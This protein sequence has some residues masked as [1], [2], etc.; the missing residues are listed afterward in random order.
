MEGRMGERFGIDS[1]RGDEIEIGQIILILWKYKVWIVACTVAA[2]LAGVVYSLFLPPVY[3]SQALITLKESDKG[4][5]GSRMLA[6]LGGFGGVVASHLGLGGASLEKIEI[7]L[8]GHDLAQNVITNHNLLPALFPGAWS[9]KDSAWKTKDPH[10]IPT[11][12]QGINFLKGKVLAV[13]LD[14]KKNIIRVGA[15]AHDSLLAKR[16]VDLYLIELNNKIRSDVM[17]DAEAKRTYL[18]SQMGSTGDPILVQKIQAMIAY[19]I[20]KQMLVSN[21]AFE[22]LESPLVPTDK[23]K[24]KRNIIAVL[25]FIVGLTFSLVAIFLKE[26]FKGLKIA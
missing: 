18:E 11:T 7:L 22:T 26:N 13:S 9:A 10:G 14:A 12:R 6:Q 8:K 4:N 16:V 24:P 21:Q 1:A 3:Y 17:K 25:S 23:S 20:E 19:E 5:D 15:N 2:T